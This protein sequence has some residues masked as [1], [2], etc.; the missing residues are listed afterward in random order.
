MKE[1][2]EPTKEALCPICK[3]EYKDTKKLFEN[4]DNNYVSNI[5]CKKCNNKFN[6]TMEIEFSYQTDSLRR[7]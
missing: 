2:I 1:W 6:I 3:F 7:V 5:V 4:N